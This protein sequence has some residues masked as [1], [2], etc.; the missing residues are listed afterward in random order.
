MVGDRGTGTA[1][2]SELHIGMEREISTS[3]L[4]ATLRPAKRTTGDGLL[5]K[6]NLTKCEA[7]V[8]MPPISERPMGLIDG[9]AADMIKSSNLTTTDK[10]EPST[11]LFLN[12]NFKVGEEARLVSRCSKGTA[13]PSRQ[14]VSTLKENAHFLWRW[15]SDDC[16]GDDD[17]NYEDCGVEWSGEEAHHSGNFQRRDIVFYCIVRDK[18]EVNKII[19]L[20]ESISTTICYLLCAVGLFAS[21]I[22]RMGGC[23]LLKKGSK[24]EPTGRSGAKSA[25][26]MI[27]NPSQKRSSLVKC[28]Q[29]KAYITTSQKYLIMSSLIFWACLVVVGGRSLAEV[30]VVDMNGLFNTVSNFVYA[31]TGVNT[32][33]SIMAFGGTVILAVGPYKC[34]EGT[35]SASI[36]PWFNMLWTHDLNGEV[37]CVGDNASC[38][39]DGENERRAM[40]VGGTGSGKLILRAL[41][42]DK[43]YAGYYG[44]GVWIHSDAS[45]DLELCIFSNN[46]ATSS[47]GGGGAIYLGDSGTT[48]NI[49]GSSFNG[50]TADEGN[51]HDIF[52][53]LSVSDS[54][55]IIIHNTCPSPYSSNTPIQGKTRM[56]IV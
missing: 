34:S 4:P 56:R 55:T 11:A 38:V 52:N 37:K 26:I 44:G 51:G 47:I 1:A 5:S 9:R 41:T 49:Y 13:P 50:N 30:N 54:G 19:S 7:A 32:G 24:I 45:V 33:T 39:L 21:L 6:L 31:G 27:M 42:F 43:G 48:V 17:G 8:I 25:A 14:S 22:V 36:N 20:Y 15:T 10:R 18:L 23:A 53:N 16:S 3:R 40:S 2:P 46:R 12:L 29:A 35:C 28:S